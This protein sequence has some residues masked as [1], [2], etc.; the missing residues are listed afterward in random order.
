MPWATPRHRPMP[1]RRPVHQVAQPDRQARRALPTNSKQWRAIRAE[2]LAREPLCRQHGKAGRVVAANEVDHV[3]GND[4]DSSPGNLQS[5]C[6]TC[7]SRKT[8][9]EQGGFGNRRRNDRSRV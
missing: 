6:K 2:Q 5:L 3:D 9:R 8:A 7:H 1:K 4:A